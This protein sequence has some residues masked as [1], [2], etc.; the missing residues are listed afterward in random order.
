MARYDSIGIKYNQYRR[1]EDRIV[2]AL[3]G[4]LGLPQD[5]TIADIGAGTGNYSNEL[6]VIFFTAEAQRAQRDLFFSFAFEREGR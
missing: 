1:A 6:A 4:L 2:S 3:K 5:S